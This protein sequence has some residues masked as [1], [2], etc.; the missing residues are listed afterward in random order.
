[1]GTV[2]LVEPAYWSLAGL[3]P[4]AHFGRGG[5][6]FSGNASTILGETGN[7]SYT[8][9]VG[10]VT[11]WDG[12]G[13][14]PRVVTGLGDVASRPAAINAAGVYVGTS[15]P[16][17]GPYIGRGFIGQ[18]GT[19][20]FMNYPGFNILGGTDINDAGWLVGPHTED[21]FA[22]IRGCIAKAFDAEIHDLGLLPGYPQGVLPQA[23][24]NAGVIVGTA[25]QGG[26]YARALYWPPGATSPTDFNLM[27][28]I[29]DTLVEAMDIN[30]AGQ[31]LARG[32]N[33]YYIFTPVPEPA[34][35]GLIALLAP[36]AAMFRR[37]GR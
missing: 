34:T 35:A 27:V 7:P 14:N 23:I 3:T 29:N 13:S 11:L 8:D 10:R 28:N 16:P 9:Y 4:M 22:S 24:N 21:N 31:I 1:M 37:R 20:T 12:D 26:T 36:A 33:G 19:A 17:Q 25:F 15:N 5:A 18:D 6:A 30:N 2:E 32:F